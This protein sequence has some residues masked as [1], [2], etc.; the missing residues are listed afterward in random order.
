MNDLSADW[1]SEYRTKAVQA[2]TSMWSAMGNIFGLIISAT[3]IVSAFSKPVVWWLLLLIMFVN[4]AGIIAVFRCFR[5][6]H[7]GY[8]DIIEDFARNRNK[9]DA[10]KIAEAIKDLQSPDLIKQSENWAFWSLWISAILFIA[11]TL[12]G[13]WICAD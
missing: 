7:K 11:F 3:S 13:L 10:E 1:I 12:K 8:L 9:S 6:V 5:L 4:F 2:R